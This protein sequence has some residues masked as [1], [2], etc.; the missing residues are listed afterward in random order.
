MKIC[1][2]G[3][4]GY[5][6]TSLTNYCLDRDIEVVR[7]TSQ[8]KIFSQRDGLCLGY[9]DLTDPSRCIAILSDVDALFYLCSPDQKTIEM[10]PGRGVSVV[11][12][13]LANILNA[14]KSLNKLKVI[15]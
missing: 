8:K 14:K 6:G 5:I 15:L 10:D 1:I 7:V 11:L 4:G 9:N 12:T 2:V 13:P 3:S